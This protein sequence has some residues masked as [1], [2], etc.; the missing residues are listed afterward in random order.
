MLFFQTKNYNDITVNTIIKNTLTSIELEVDM[1]AVGLPM[2]LLGEL[3]L[4]GVV[5]SKGGL[6]TSGGDSTTVVASTVRKY[7]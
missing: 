2:L 6:S 3:E 5:L 1:M 4:D 7:G